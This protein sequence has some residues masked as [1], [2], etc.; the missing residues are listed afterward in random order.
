MVLGS[1]LSLQGWHWQKL[2]LFR[3]YCCVSLEFMSRL[4]RNGHL[5]Q[6]DCVE[7]GTLTTRMVSLEMQTTWVSLMMPNGNGS[8][9]EMSS[10]KHSTS[11]REV[12][13]KLHFIFDYISIKFLSRAFD[14]QI[15]IWWCQDINR[16]KACRNYPV[17]LTFERWCSYTAVV[18]ALN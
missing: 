16:E 5:N 4:K 15:I 17:F 8:L 13:I 7:V 1:C 3:E 10:V 12:S 2:K 6:K 14:Y 11:M 9:L 18:G